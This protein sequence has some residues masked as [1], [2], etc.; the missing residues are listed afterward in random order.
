MAVSTEDSKPSSITALGCQTPETSPT[1]PSALTPWGLGESSRAAARISRT[2][3]RES[4]PELSASVAG[5]V[6]IARAKASIANLARPGSDSL[7]FLTAFAIL[8]WVAPPPANSWP[9]SSAIL[10]ALKASCSPRITSSVA[11]SPAPPI[12][13]VTVAGVLQSS[14]VITSST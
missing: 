3:S 10:V 6:S 14:M 5:T 2:V 12:A 11:V 4:F 1:S 7:A 13:R 9:S 8:A